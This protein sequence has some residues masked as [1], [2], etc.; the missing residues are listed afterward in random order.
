VSRI[1]AATLRF[2]GGTVWTGDRSAPVTDAVLVS[3]GVVVALGSEAAERAGHGVETV[4]LAGRTL[5]PGFRD[6]HVHPL[7]AGF[8]LSA[9]PVAG[10]ASLDELLDRVRAY[11]EAHPELPAITGGGYD[12][13]LSPGGLFD[14]ELLDRAVPDRPAV[15]HASD[16]HTA[17]VNSAAIARLG[18]GPSTPDPPRGR[19]ARRADG[20]PLGTLMEAATDLAEPL[21]PTPDTAARV[22]ALRVALRALAEAGIVWGL[23]ALVQP[24]EAEAYLALAASGGLT[25]RFG[26]AIVLSPERWRESLDGAIATRATVDAAGTALVEASTVKL[27]ADG[28]IETG[29]AALL[30]PYLAADGRAGNGDR[31]IPNWSGGSLDE[32]VAAAAAAGFQIHVH[33]IGDAGVRAALD[34]FEHAARV[35]GRPPRRPTIAHTQLVH[36]D[37]LPRFVKLGVVANFEPLWAQLDPCMTDLTI[38]RLGPERSAL[39][40]PMGELWRSGARLSMGS[41]WPVSSVVPLEG[42]AVAV[43]RQTPDGDPPGGW[44]PDQRLPLDAALAA[45]TAGTAWQAFEETIAGTITAGKRADLCLL[46]ADVATLAPDELAGVPVEGTWLGGVAVHRA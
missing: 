16:Y 4:D 28:V 20:S 46:G 19:I 17:W 41:D 21:Q 42:I 45:Y 31:G 8:S 37:D 30:E 13:A 33:A 36:P 12:P 40:Y 6:G 5:V 23:D 39:Q 27:F 26:L 10:A 32:A 25:C 7:H 29:T 15:L 35:N 3:D 14:A 34:A 43:T 44:L 2:A 1:S 11:A 22:A 38:P 18:I 24:A 9:A